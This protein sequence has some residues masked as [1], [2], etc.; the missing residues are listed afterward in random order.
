VRVLVYSDDA[1]FVSE[2]PSFLNQD[3]FKLKFAPS[4]STLLKMLDDAMFHVVLFQVT[5]L[6]YIEQL[7]ALFEHTTRTPVVLVT[8]DFIH[9]GLI[10][11]ISLGAQ[12]VI[13]LADTGAREVGTR[14]RFAIE[15]HRLRLEGS[16]VDREILRSR[17]NPNGVELHRATMKLR[18]ATE[19]FARMTSHAKA[20]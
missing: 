4:F 7:K 18:S 8:E 16:V 6:S 12:D 5:E 19:N 11:G 17:R 14:V 10:L 15:R 9:P 20:I 3:G 1:D 2:L 13:C